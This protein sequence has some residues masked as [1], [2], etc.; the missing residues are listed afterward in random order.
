MSAGERTLVKPYL[1]R[2]FSR[3][4]PAEGRALLLLSY[5]SAHVA[6]AAHD[7]DAFVLQG[8]LALGAV[9]ELREGRVA[10]HE[11]VGVEGDAEAGAELG[12]ALG[13]VLAAAVGEEE[14]GDVVRLE[15]VEGFAGAWEGLGA[16]E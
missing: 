6:V 3:G 1:P 2:F 9:D 13:F 16:A 8:F 4:E 14:E 5:F 12:D 11:E 15:V 10:L 7:E